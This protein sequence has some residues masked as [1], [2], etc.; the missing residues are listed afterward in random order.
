MM[1][2][3]VARIVRLPI[4][5]IGELRGVIYRTAKGRG[6]TP[7][8]YVHFFNEPLP[9]L[10]TNPSGTRLYIIGGRYRVGTKGIEG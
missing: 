9:S 3:R 4:A 1:K 2:F 10:M 6:E 7:R 5:A 8:N